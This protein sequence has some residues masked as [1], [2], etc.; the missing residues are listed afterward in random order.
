MDSLG[1]RLLSLLPI[2]CSSVPFELILFFQKE[3]NSDD[4]AYKKEYHDE[5]MKEEYASDS[6]NFLSE[7][8]IIFVGLIAYSSQKV[9][10]LENTAKVEACKKLSFIKNNFL[11][12]YHLYH[13]KKDS[14]VC[15]RSLSRDRYALSSFTWSRE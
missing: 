4:D 9:E 3:E 2:R 13:E 5:D 8:N 11:Y 10:K 6:G 1:Q 14:K 15:D 12:H 7:R